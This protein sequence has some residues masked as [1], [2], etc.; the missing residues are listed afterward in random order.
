MC[1]CAQEH[2]C[3]GLPCGSLHLS[4]IH[5]R[6]EKKCVR[7]ETDMNMIY[8]YIYIYIYTHTHIYIHTYIDIDM[9]IHKLEEKLICADT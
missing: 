2:Q 5:K 6:N 7:K 4:H 9:H 8:V 3:L 1:L